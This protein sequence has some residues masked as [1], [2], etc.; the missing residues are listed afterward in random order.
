MFTRAREPTWLLVVLYVGGVRE[1]TVPLSW[2]L[3]SFQSLP[4]LPT[5]KLGPSGAASRVG[6][7]VCVC[8]RTLWVCPTSSPVRLGVSPTAAS[9][10]TGVF[11]QRFGGF[12]FL[13]QNPGLHG[14]SCFPVVPPGLSACKCGTACSAS[15]RLARPSPLAATLPCVLSTP[16][17]CLRPSYWSG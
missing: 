14:L 8:S 6:G 2:L 17:V 5:S 9:T 7:C 3:A 16:A 11:S 15:C 13:S 12:I 4:P 10:P 1:G